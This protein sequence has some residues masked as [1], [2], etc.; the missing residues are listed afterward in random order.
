MENKY[1]TKRKYRKALRMKNT[2]SLRKRWIDVLE[3][4]ELE[5]GRE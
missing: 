1:C 3:D 2:D 5:A 4:W